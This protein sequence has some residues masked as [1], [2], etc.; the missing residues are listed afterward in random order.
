MQRF[1]SV[2][3]ADHPGEDA[4]QRHLRLAFGPDDAGLFGAVRPLASDAIRRL[5]GCGTFRSLQTLAAAEG[6][7]LNAF[8]LRRLREAVSQPPS[9]QPT[10]F[11]RSGPPKLP[12][13]PVQATYRGGVAEPLHNWYPYLEGYSPEF[14]KK[15]LETFAPSASRVLDPFA[16]TGTTPL[17]A[18]MTARQSFYCELNPV[19]QFLVEAKTT[20]LALP[21]S[22]RSRLAGRVRSVAAS[23]ESLADHEPD[24]RLA[25][26]FAASFG[27]AAFFSP[28]AMD[29]TLRLRTWLDRLWSD[30]TPAA[31]VATVAVLASLVPGSNMIRRGDLRFRKGDERRKAVAD[32]PGEVGRRLQL[33]AGDIARLQTAAGSATLIAGDAKRLDRLP[34]LEVEAIVTS[35]PYLNG[36][37]YYRNTKIE[38]WFLRALSS[39]KDLAAFRRQTVTAGINDVTAEKDEP[40]VSA[41]VEETV[42]SLERQAY[43]RRI[44]VMVSSYFADMKQ[45]LSG[46]LRHANPGSPLLMDIGDSSYAGVRVD[47]PALLADLLREDGWMVRREMTLRQRL[48]RNGQTLRQVLLFAA[49]PQ[50]ARVSRRTVERWR[51]R[52]EAF[53]RDLPHQQGDFAKRNWGSPLH[54]LC[55]Y[56]GKLKP[57]LAHHLVGAFTAPGDRL[58]DP[59]GGVGTIA[60]E[61]ARSGVKS[62]SFDISPVAVPVAAAKLDPATA[63]DVTA[64]L[65][66]LDRFLSTHRATKAERAE[67]DSIRFNGPLRTYYHPGTLDE[68]LLARRFFRENPPSAPAAALVF[69]CLLHILHGNRPYALSRRSHPITPFSPTGPTEYRKLMTRLTAKVRRSLAVTRPSTFVAGSSLSQDATSHWPPCVENLDAVI[70]SPPF[71]DSTRFHLANWIRLW[72]AGWT[73]A[74]FKDRPTAFV[75]E[76]QKKG[77]GVYEAVLRQARERLKPDGVCIFHLGKSR[78]C[79]M[80]SELAEVARPWFRKVEIFSESVAHCESHGIRDKGTVFEHRYLVMNDSDSVSRRFRPAPEDGS[81][82]DARSRRYPSSHTSESSPGLF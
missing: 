45:I 41:G 70:T 24:S 56:Q 48:S 53:R 6:R 49:A 1:K 28:V 76:R 64:T 7:S 39:G 50:R 32:L 52:W 75:E 9:D 47:T 30:D 2:Y 16:G 57:S 33:M 21:S 44:P 80:A 74:D 81:G 60:F 77:F 22:A 61:A 82:H 10:L 46:F 69:A 65:S 66:A 23:L 15:V 31:K 27:D 59:F 38:L 17:T 42:R 20:V 37:N 35:P 36:T 78:K 34:G 67:A 71:Y 19:L 55:S 13:S 73:G 8:S 14:V 62:W 51:P 58:L 3:F 25:A 5:L 12:F 43:D 68:I 79:D 26:T 63:G 4:K 29:A 72:F 54:S 11:S 40:P 18:A